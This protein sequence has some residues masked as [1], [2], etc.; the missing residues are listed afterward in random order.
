MGSML[1]EGVYC[2]TVELFLMSVVK[3]IMEGKFQFLPNSSTSICNPVI[4]QQNSVIV[5]SSK[6][7]LSIRR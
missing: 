1:K 2:R 5:N 7:L 4:N 6:L 3:P